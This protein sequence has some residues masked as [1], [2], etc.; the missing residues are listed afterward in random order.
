M[1]PPRP[2]RVLGYVRLSSFAGEADTTTS[3]ERQEEV[4]RQYS[5][6]HGWDV[7]DVIHDLDV[8]GSDKGLRLDRPGLLKVRARWDEID[9]LV[10]AKLDRVARNVA[11]WEKLREEAEAHGVALVS[12]AENLDLST[13]SGRFVATILQAFAAME[14]AMISTRTREAVAYLAREGRHRG[15][16]A[17]FG[18]RAALR[19]DGPGYRLELDPDRAPIVR[20]AVD[21]I[22]AGEPVSVV[23]DD[24]TRR[25]L[26]SPEGNGWTAVALRRLLCRPILR[27]HQVHR[28]EVVRGADGLPIQPHDALVS[29]AEWA[30]LH[31]ALA[32]RS[33][34]STRTEEAPHMLLRG[35]V[36]CSYCLARLHAVT[37]PGKPPVWSCSG[38][39]RT[40]SGDRCPGVVISRAR[41]EEHLLGEVMAAVGDV[42][43]VEVI[44]EERADDE[45]LELEAALDVIFAKL[46]NVDNDDEEDLLLA[47]RRTIRNRLRELRDRP[48]RTEPVFRPT[49]TTFAEDWAAADEAGRA[50]LLRRVLSFVTV[51]KGQ[52]GRHGLDPERL[53]VLYNPAPVPEATDLDV[54]GVHYWAADA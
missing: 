40:P 3:P 21:R 38:R 11:D 43:G 50:E 31:E 27:G 34:I 6:A 48:T 49:G 51:K 52:R 46:R 30:A 19:T 12:V 8:S 5:A 15:G 17:A 45:A 7:V 33:R 2:R 35:V 1:T 23:A 4:I 13:P 28:G 26:A 24:F 39:K 42:Q 10:F 29:A 47:Q 32:L 54:G 18:W 41:L 22:T 9:V 16:L 20:E 53:T 44:V 25:E 36:V 37:Q 14:A